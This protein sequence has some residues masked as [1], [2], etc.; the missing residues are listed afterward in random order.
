M[1]KFK[2]YMQM[3]MSMREEQDDLIILLIKVEMLQLDGCFSCWKDG[4]L[5]PSKDGFKCKGY[6]M[7]EESLSNQQK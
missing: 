5:S 6:M 1:Q 3:G 7:Y 4:F 2:K